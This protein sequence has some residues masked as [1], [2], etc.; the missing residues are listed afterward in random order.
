MQAGW[1]QLLTPEQLMLCLVLQLLRGTLM[2]CLVLL[3]LRT[4]ET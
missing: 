4:K 3:D 1:M 2:L